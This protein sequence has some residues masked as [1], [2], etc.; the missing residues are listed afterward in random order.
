MS[1][2]PTPIHT[3]LASPETKPWGLRV[4]SKCHT[5][6]GIFLYK[7]SLQTFRRPACNFHGC[8]GYFVNT[9]LW[10]KS[11]TYGL[12][13]RS[14]LA[15]ETSSQRRS[16][17]CTSLYRPLKRWLR[18][19]EYVNMLLHIHV[20]QRFTIELVNRIA[21]FEIPGWSRT[22]NEFAVVKDKGWRN[23]W[24]SSIYC[25][26]SHLS[27]WEWGFFEPEPL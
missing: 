17:I 18:R 10:I 26:F 9:A 3:S 21:W 25:I 1:Y 7:A 13:Q 27:M 23:Q 6:F 4:A 15:W 24:Y 16:K 12:L 14:S 20:L 2:H 19:P 8:Q 5:Q 11:N 22:C